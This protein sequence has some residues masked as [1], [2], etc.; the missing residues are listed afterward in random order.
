MT[1]SRSFARAGARS[2]CAAC[3]AVAAACLALLLTGRLASDRW[4]WSQAL[5]WIPGAIPAGA[6]LLAA[7]GALGAALAARWPAG[8]RLALAVL[9]AALGA[10]A[11]VGIFQ[12]RLGNLLRRGPPPAQAMTI[13][14]WNATDVTPEEFRRAVAARK[15]DVLIAINPPLSVN[16]I[17]LAGDLW[18]LP[19]QQAIGRVRSG[20]RVVI[21]SR[22]AP[23]ASGATDL[24]LRGM[25]AGSPE[26]RIDRGQAVFAALD[27]DGAPLTIWAIDLPSDPALSRAASARR[28]R[29]AIDASRHTRHVLVESG[30]FYEQR[31]STGF[32]APDVIV[33]D[34]NTTRGA[35][36][37]APL[38]G[39]L[40]SAHARAGAGPDGTWP[41][42]W[43]LLGLDQAFV[44]RSLRIWRYDVFDAGAGSHRAQEL[45]ISLPAR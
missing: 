40:T 1:P 11:W 45:T 13:L 18:D 30:A 4:A 3:A 9:I 34:F 36:S 16:W 26:Q 21:A 7:L 31:E 20:G 24:D 12:W 43:W 6:A 41:R 15:P 17:G 25:V 22:F 33:G 28:A 23:S 2:A 39:G 37:L 8:R 35:A 44:R 27:V 42:P 19:P 29:A 5:F 32:P 38:V 10:G 14:G